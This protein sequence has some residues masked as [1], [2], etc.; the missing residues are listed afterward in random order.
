MSEASLKSGRTTCVGSNSV[1]SSPASAGGAS[2]P[3]SPASLTTSPC[4][5]DPVPVSHSRALATDVAIPTSG[6]SGP[7]F[8][9]SSPSAALQQSLESKL[10]AVLA[11]SGSP[12]YE[13]TW[14]TWDM[15]LGPPICRLRASA[16]RTSGSGYSGWPTPVARDW[17]DGRSNLHGQNARPLN[18]VAMLASGPP[19]NICP[20]ETEKPGQL[21]P[22][23][24]R[25]LMGFLAVWDDCAPTAMRSS[26]KSPR[27]S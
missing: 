23:F 8:T 6:T 14:S 27:R 17:H 15:P 2:P 20:A 25:W 4:G 7:L 16:H 3:G 26:R 24:S 19:S 21:N 13:L 22:A 9:H 18:E 5:Q 1:T 12:L 11:G 10:R